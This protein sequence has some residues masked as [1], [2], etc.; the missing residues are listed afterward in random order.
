MHASIF[1]HP[2]LSDLGEKLSCGSVRVVCHSE[3]LTA[4]SLG[5]SQK[6]PY[7]C[8]CVCTCAHFA[9]LCDRGTIPQILCYKS[10]LLTL[11]H[12]DPVAGGL[13]PFL[14]Q[15]VWAETVLLRHV[16]GDRRCLLHSAAHKHFFGPK[17]LGVC[18]RITALRSEDTCCRFGGRHCEETQGEQRP[19][20]H[21]VTP[22]PQPSSSHG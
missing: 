2:I 19:G 17:S 14:A 15:L 7:F 16:P 21:A 4:F 8:V 12:Q 11:A 22:S 13:T 20:K 3:P 6:E 1:K 18:S 5:R 10:V 9:E